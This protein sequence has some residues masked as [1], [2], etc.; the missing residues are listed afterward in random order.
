MRALLTRLRSTSR[1][2]W[3]ALKKTAKKTS[4][5]AVA[6]FEVMPRPNQMTKSEASTMRGIALAALMNG[7]HTSAGKRLRPSRMPRTTP[8]S[9]PMTKPS[10]ASCR[11]VAIC[12]QTEPWRGAVGEPVDEP[13]PDSVGLE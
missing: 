7:A 11:V 12:V 8:P 3:K 13:V 6:T 1:A 9:A 4:T 2:P 10:T 5:T